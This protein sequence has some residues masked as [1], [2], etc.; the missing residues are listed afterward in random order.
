MRLHQLYALCLAVALSLFLT[1][2]PIATTIAPMVPGAPRISQCDMVPGAPGCP[3]MRRFGTPGTFGPTPAVSLN[4]AGSSYSGCA[5]AS[6]CLSVARNQ[7]NDTAQTAENTVSYF[8]ANTLRITDLGL[9]RENAATNLLQQSLN[10]AASPWATFNVGTGVAPVVTANAGVAPDGNTTAALVVINRVAAGSGDDSEVYQP[11]T[12]TGTTYSGSVWLEAGSAGDIGKNIQVAAYN[13]TALQGVTTIALT[14]SWQRVCIVG[15]TMAAS[16]Q[17]N[18]GYM[19]AG[20]PTGAATFL[21]W[22]GQEELGSHCSSLIPTTTS[23]VTRPADVITVSGAFLSLIESAAGSLIFVTDNMGASVAQTLLGVGATDVA[24]L[25]YTAGG[26][27]TSGWGGSTINSVGT[28]LSSNPYLASGVEWGAGSSAI[29]ING[30]TPVA[31]GAISAVTAANLGSFQDA[32]TGAVGF[33]ASIT[34]YST[35]LAS[36]TFQGFTVA[37]PAQTPPFR[38]FSAANAYSGNPIA[39][40]NT[41]AA[42]VGAQSSPYYSTDTTVSGTIYGPAGARN[43]ANTSPNQG[44]QN[45]DLMSAAAVLTSPWTNNGVILSAG[46]TTW[47]SSYLLHPSTILCPA[48]VGATFCMYYSGM[49][50]TTGSGGNEAIGLATANAMTGPWTK[51]AGNPLTPTG[52]ALPHILKTATQ[53]VMFVAVRPN[54]L[55]IDYFTSPLTDGINWTFG[56]IA[57]NTVSTDWDYPNTTRLEDPDVEQNAEG[58]CEMLYTDDFDTTFFGQNIGYATSWDCIHFTKRQQA[59]QLGTSAAY[60]G[61]PTMHETPTEFFFLYDSLVNSGNFPVTGNV[62]SIP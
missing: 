26:A 27:A 11:W 62:S 59:I 44:W 29:A 46:T 38:D 21:A 6:A 22:G 13:G 57:L 50:G 15:P 14:A 34:G 20:G 37:S 23:T 52:Y 1:S 32:T 24:G 49:T 2:A 7:A 42:N 9:L 45:L 5:S 54:G 40:L 4:F 53:Y 41:I 16:S 35:K 47:D 48:S 51:Y 12:G 56:G 58:Y 10:L 33:F 43:V 60:N 3:M 17:F 36:A 8:A 25:G 55:T 61:D 28:W 31:G 39:P 30:Q 18:I 19:A